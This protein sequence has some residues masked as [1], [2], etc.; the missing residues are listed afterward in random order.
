M[1]HTFINLKLY[2]DDNE[3]FNNGKND[4]FSKFIRFMSHSTVIS[5]SSLIATFSWLIHRKSK[6]YLLEYPLRSL[7]QIGCDT[8]CTQ[9]G[10]M[11]VAGLL[12]PIYRPLVPLMLLLSAGYFSAHKTIE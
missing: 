8:I 11:Y 1:S 6:Y 9:I 4:L 5:V 10:A 3:P 2:P 12:S 7:Y